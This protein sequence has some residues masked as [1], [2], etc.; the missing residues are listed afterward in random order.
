MKDWAEE[1]GSSTNRGPVRVRVL[2][3]YS[4]LSTELQMRVF[5]PCPADER[6]IVVAT[7][8]AETSLTIPGIKYVVDSGREKK[9]VYD[10]VTGTS[11]FVVGWISK[12]SANQRTGRAGRTGPGHCYRVYS[13]AC[14][15]DQFE[16]FSAPEILRNP[17]E[18]S[19]LQ[20][21]AMG[22]DRIDTFPF[23]T[24]PDREG[25]RHALQTLQVLGAIERDSHK[26]SALG[27]T[28]AA[29]PVAP[30]YA[31]ML[32]MGHQGG[33]MP[34][35]MAVV[36]S[37]SVQE[38]FLQPQLSETMHEAEA[39]GGE[40]GE[41]EDGEGDEE[42]D[43]EAALHRKQG[44]A[45]RAEGKLRAAKQAEK[46]RKRQA[47]RSERRA[48][49]QS[50]FSSA[51]AKWRHHQ[52]DLLTNLRVV[53][54]FDWVGRQD[55]PTATAAAAARR[56]GGGREEREDSALRSEFQRREFCRLN[57]LRLKSM[58]EV[59]SLREQLARICADI[60]VRRA[61][62]AE[63]EAGA[64]VETD[65]AAGQSARGAS[66]SSE[67]VEATATA[68]YQ[69]LRAVPN[70]PSAEQELVLRQII[71]AGLI[72]QVARK[73]PLENRRALE[74]AG[75]EPGSDG[76]LADMSGAYQCVSTEEPIF[77]H[78][79][80]NL[81]DRE[82]QPEWLVYH[83][84]SRTSKLYAKGLTAIDP[85]W[86]A[87]LGPHLCTRSAPLETPSPCFNAEADAVM[88]FVNVSFGPNH[89]PLPMDQQPF[90]PGMQRTRHFGRLFLD[91]QV[92]KPLAAFR[93]FMT[94]KPSLITDATANAKKIQ[95]M[96][97]ALV[98][99]DVCTKSKLVDTW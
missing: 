74:E 32:V 89:W 52:S 90:P 6:L 36:A 44:K 66:A 75:R 37:L 43:E 94:A 22:I 83:E 61:R 40:S 21:K 16:E 12:A 29:F 81:F 27:R 31:K 33:C 47:E 34:Y 5:E 72:D 99:A 49:L 19:V 25:L 76:S 35:V 85:R 71:T 38:I 9:K 54:G 62:P 92:C 82:R 42:G 20:M 1:S 13:G 97:T 18:P 39:A 80:S 88:C 17:I 93:P 77:L 65:E 23:P 3:L 67:S 4:M 14:F 2:P 24:P 91:G 48:A 84:L 10:K 28:L 15:G 58:A 45:L 7:N 56:C 60:L 98:K 51:R 41:D 63:A 30:R 78:P 59:A 50:S 96:L 79:T 68:L 55:Q 57:F 46:E 95:R 87:T 69:S 64:E 26:I 86:L 70:P 53:G 73:M 8:V 11:Q